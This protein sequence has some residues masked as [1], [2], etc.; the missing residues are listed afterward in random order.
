M[1]GLL[2]GAMGGL[3]LAVVAEYL[4]QTFTTGRELEARLGIP[5][6][7]TIPDQESLGRTS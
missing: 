4:D 3:G 5:L 1:L 2:L 6:L 7:G